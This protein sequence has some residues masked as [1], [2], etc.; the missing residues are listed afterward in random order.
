MNNQHKTLIYGLIVLVAV[1]RLLPHPMGVTAVGA[2]G[3]FSGAYLSKRIAWTVPLIA[4]LIGDL[5][6]GFYSPVVMV[7]VYS[8]FAVSAIIGRWLLM[9]Q[10]TPSRLGGSVLLGAISFYLLS[11]FGMWIAAYPHTID[12]L[13]LCYVNGLP[14]LARSLLGDAFYT[15]LLFGSFEMMNAWLNS[16]QQG[17]RVT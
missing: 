5:I 6:S 16:H 4:L 10:R 9:K 13:I 1:S 11:N 15:V 14:Y 3:L 2:L 8:G 12:G 7:F 17:S